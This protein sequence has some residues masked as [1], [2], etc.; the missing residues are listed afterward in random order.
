MKHRLSNLIFRDARI[1]DHTCASL[2]LLSLAV[3][4]LVAANTPSIGGGVSKTAPMAA[5]PT[6]Q[7]PPA[8]GHDLVTWITRLTRAGRDLR[9]LNEPAAR[10]I[11]LSGIA[12]AF[13]MAVHYDS[14]R[15]RPTQC[16]PPE[17]DKWQHCYVGCEISTW[18]PVGTLSA[19]ALAIMKELR[20]VIDNGN[21]SWPDILATFKG[22]WDCPILVPCEAFCCRQFG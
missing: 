22:A 2:A 20:D 11:V 13:V 17:L 3:I 10:P 16:R 5:A 18:C 9:Y 21:F 1:P 14:H 12:S 7:A 4:T 8:P 15:P 6:P 19:S